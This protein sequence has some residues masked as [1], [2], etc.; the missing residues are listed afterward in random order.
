MVVLV[1]DS[2]D[3]RERNSDPGVGTH[4]HTTTPS[5][6]LAASHLQDITIIARVLKTYG[7]R[8]WQDL[9]NLGTGLS[10]VRIRD[11]I[12]NETSGLLFYSTPESVSSEFVRQV[13]L[14]EAQA[15]H[16]SNP[17][18]FIVPVFRLPI[19]ETDAALKGTLT[20]PVSSFNGAKIDRPDDPRAIGDAAH[21]AAELVLQRSML[22]RRDPLPIG[23]TVKQT[24]PS[25]VSLDIDFTPFFKNGLP[26]EEE[27]NIDFPRALHRVKSALLARSL[28]R[29]RLRT[30]AHLSLGLL[31]GFVFRER[32]GFRLEIEQATRGKE[33]S[34]WTTPEEALPHG[35]SMSEY[36][37]Q[38]DSR[39]L[40]VKINL[41][42]R[43]DAS[44]AAYA[45]KSGLA[46]RVLLDVTPPAY[47]H[48]ISSGHAVGIA[49]DLADRIKEIHGRYGTNFVHLC[50]AW[51]RHIDRLQPKCL[52]VH[53]ML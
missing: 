36:P 19:S 32:T 17:N 39:N 47:P 22:K 49:R 29:L 10:E 20:V 42:A 5:R 15:A 38:L 23:L 27:W 33:T 1:R 53:P 4:I 35:L 52:R 50:A 3:Q 11:A 45:V 44:V 34:V 48:F 25:G 14:T 21:R 43:D 12:Q 28:T 24:S 26:C 40:C 51:T 7:I 8:T 31:F 46:Y 18:F 13:E 41:V 6:R 16:R 2:S 37:A 9:D 30:F